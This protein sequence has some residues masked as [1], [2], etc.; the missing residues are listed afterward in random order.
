M[1]LLK[2]SCAALAM[3]VVSAAS[4]QALKDVPPEVQAAHLATAR[5]C[6]DMGKKL[7][8]GPDYVMRTD[9]NSDG[10]TDYVLDHHALECIGAASIFG[11]GSAGTPYDVFVSSGDRYI[12]RG[13]IGEN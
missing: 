3:F 12:Q 10:K 8:I 4:A 5:M 9:F 11:G 6:I 2:C 1:R 13:V 7:E